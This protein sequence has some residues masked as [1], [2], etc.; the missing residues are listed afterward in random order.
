MQRIEFS[1]ADVT[2]HDLRV[3][4]GERFEQV[5]THRSC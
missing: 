4:N 5:R 2:E 3:Q 1:I